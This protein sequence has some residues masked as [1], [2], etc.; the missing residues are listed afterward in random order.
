LSYETSRGSLF[1]VTSYREE[2]RRVASSIESERVLLL[3]VSCSKS[4]TQLDTY[5]FRKRQSTTQSSIEAQAQ[6]IV[7]CPVSGQE[8]A[9][10]VLSDVKKDEA[11]VTAQEI[12][13]EP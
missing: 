2:A 3:K 5:K 1:R 12:Q 7:F 10:A 8:C 13:I 9:N 11:N 4:Q 6:C